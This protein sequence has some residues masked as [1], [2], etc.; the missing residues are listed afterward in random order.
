MF[1]SLPYKMPWVPFLKARYKWH[2]L[3]LLIIL[4][5]CV[6]CAICFKQTKDTFRHYSGPC[7]KVCMF[8]HTKLVHSD[9]Q[10]GS[11]YSMSLWMI[12]ERTHSRA[13]PLIMMDPSPA[14]CCISKLP[15][16]GY[17]WYVVNC[18]MKLVLDAR[19]IGWQSHILQKGCFSESQP[20][21]YS[22]SELID[23][24]DAT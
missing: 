9:L 5:S 2:L 13:E 15:S 4:C 20:A 18:S 21:E 16:W 8:N 11:K 6:K 19:Q 10:W 22:S 24:T 1:L 12:S 14:L 23:D 17:S 7:T 3:L